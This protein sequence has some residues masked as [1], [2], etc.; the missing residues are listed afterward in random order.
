MQES[1]A[2]SCW[3][4]VAT[5]SWAVSLG[6]AVINIVLSVILVQV[7]GLPGGGL[8]TTIPLSLLSLLYVPFAAIRLVGGRPLGFLREAFLLR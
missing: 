7:I 3:G 5:G 4:L 8:G 6:S 2:I 1:A